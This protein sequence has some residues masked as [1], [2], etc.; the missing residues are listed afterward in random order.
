MKSE[1]I[2]QAINDIEPEL[3][4][5]A[6][7][8]HKKSATRISLVW[9]TLAACLL[10]VIGLVWRFLALPK[11]PV[12]ENALYSAEDIGNMLNRGTLGASTSAYK[13]VY[14][15]GAE[16]LHINPLPNEEYL[17]IYQYSA[18][19]HDLNKT[20]FLDFLGATFPK[21]ATGLGIGIPTFEVAQNANS[22]ST[23]VLHID[24][25]WISAFQNS[26]RYYVDIGTSTHSVPDAEI[27]IAGKPVQIGLS[28]ND[29]EIIKSLT[30]AKEALFQIF[31]TFF[32][33][34]QVVRSYS[35]CGPSSA[36]W[37]TVYFYNKSDHPLNSIENSKYSDYIAL[38]FNAPDAPD[39]TVMWC[40]SV[41]FCDYRSDINEIYPLY[42]RAKQISLQDAE[43]FLYHGY[44]FGG[45][46][47]RICMQTQKSVD[48]TNYDYVELSYLSG[49]PNNNTTTLIP[50]YAFYKK[51]GIAENGNE[52][53]AK[54]YVPAIEVSGYETYFESQ[55][56]QHNP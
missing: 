11:I 35:D 20:E 8:N 52:I 48:F 15:P 33:D 25:Y 51:I 49:S 16:Y 13:E 54:T 12:Y 24:R 42:T 34:V 14:V 38:E 55:V 37:I 44:V 36:D 7:G 9:G 50:F 21:I 10:L 6:E 22:Y 28:Q 17:P 46:N 26:S 43:A 18:P 19:Q 39:N 30:S 3:V 5:D 40:V 53:Y 47:C 41:I 29:E 2:L 45:H 4:A 56:A 32:S 31:D 27:V 1:N 23:P